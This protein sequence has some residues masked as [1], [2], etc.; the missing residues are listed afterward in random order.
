M[1]P[2]PYLTRP[3]DL[4]RV[5]G[6]ENSVELLE[7]LDDR[8]DPRANLK[9]DLAARLAEAMMVYRRGDF[10]EARTL[11]QALAYKDPEDKLYTIFR[12]RIEE[13]IRLGTPDGWDGTNIFDAK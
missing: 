13:F 5:K 11:F 6:K 4:V 10:F 9:V 7:I 1:D 8:F 2:Q 3:V 12:R